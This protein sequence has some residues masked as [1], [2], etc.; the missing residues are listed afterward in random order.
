LVTIREN[1]PSGL[2]YGMP[3]D[4]IKPNKWFKYL[5]RGFC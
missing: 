4:P 3:P 2:A 1:G 5:F